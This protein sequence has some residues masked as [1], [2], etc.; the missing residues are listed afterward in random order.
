MAKIIS[1]DSL[2][3][4]GLYEWDTSKS[5]YEHGRHYLRRTVKGNCAL[6]FWSGEDLKALGRLFDLASTQP[7]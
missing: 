3:A 2:I 4:D 5:V 6:A 1:I 7:A